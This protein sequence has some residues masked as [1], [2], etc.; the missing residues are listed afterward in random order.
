MISIDVYC[1]VIPHE[2][3]V[4]LHELRCVCRAT[5][6]LAHDRAAVGVAHRGG[7]AGRAATCSQQPRPVARNQ[8]GRRQACYATREINQNI[9]T[10]HI[11]TEEYPSR[12]QRNHAWVTASSRGMPSASYPTPSISSERASAEPHSSLLADA[13]ALCHAGKDMRPARM[14]DH[15]CNGP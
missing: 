15:R 3:G 14:P 6:A 2:Y 1:S 11:A 7:M 9:G 4:E 13:L 12:C 5:R 8:L 10:P